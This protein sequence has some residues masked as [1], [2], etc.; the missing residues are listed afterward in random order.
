MK[1][2]IILVCSIIITATAFAQINTTTSAV[3][4]N[5]RT[6]NN[7]ALTKQ[8]VAVAVINTNRDSIEIS[9]LY[10]AYKMADAEATYKLQL[11]IA[12]MKEVQ[13]KNNANETEQ[14]RADREMKM[15]Q[16]RSLM[17]NRTNQLKLTTN[18]LSSMNQGLNTISQNLK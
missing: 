7:S 11:I 4:G 8:N 14:E 10:E 16:L 18:I 5:A 12:K 2:S 15:V 1:K 9:Q 17:E 13:A 3:K 6:F